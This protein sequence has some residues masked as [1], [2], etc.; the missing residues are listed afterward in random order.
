MRLRIQAQV[1]DLHIDAKVLLTGEPVVHSGT[2]PRPADHERPGPHLPHGKLL[3]LVCEDQGAGG[4]LFIVEPR[5]LNSQF[6]R[7]HMAVDVI[8]DHDAQLVAPRPQRQDLLVDRLGPHI[9]GKVMLRNVQSRA[10]LKGI[11]DPASQRA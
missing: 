9:I 3:D 6:H 2:H 7:T 10:F 4:K 11:Y 8:L 1:I 5:H